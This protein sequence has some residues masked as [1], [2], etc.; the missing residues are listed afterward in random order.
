MFLLT[1]FFSTKLKRKIFSVS[2]DGEKSLTPVNYIFGEIRRYKHL[3][4]PIR[5]LWII[6]S[7]EQKSSVD[8]S[9]SEKHYINL[10][11]L[12]YFGKM[13][14]KTFNK[15]N[16]IWVIINGFRSMGAKQSVRC[17]KIYY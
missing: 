10:Q 14:G 12:H 15:D 3:F 11:M 16:K 7:W 5:A 6:Y 4:L 13:T 1:S 17:S 9:T 2:T 8:K